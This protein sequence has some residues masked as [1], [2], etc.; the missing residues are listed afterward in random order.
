MDVNEIQCANET[1]YKDNMIL[2][3]FMSY[4]IR[5]LSIFGSNYFFTGM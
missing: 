3:H 1:S 2:S 4:N 5:S